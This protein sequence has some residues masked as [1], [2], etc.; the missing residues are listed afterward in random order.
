MKTVRYNGKYPPLKIRWSI[1]EDD[2]TPRWKSEDI[3]RLSDLLD[4]STYIKHPE[5]QTDRNG[6]LSFEYMSFYEIET[7]EWEL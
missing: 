2:I 5:L 4:F 7:S 1:V 3:L 6:S